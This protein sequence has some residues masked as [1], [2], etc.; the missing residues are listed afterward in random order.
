MELK[1]HELKIFMT[2]LVQNYL[3]TILLKSRKMD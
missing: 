3:I 2:L 1:S